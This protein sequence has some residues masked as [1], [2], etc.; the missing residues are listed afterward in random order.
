MKRYPTGPLSLEPYIFSMCYSYN[1]V[2]HP[3]DCDVTVIPGKPLLDP[4]RG[5]G[6]FR[7]SPAGFPE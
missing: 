3:V 5:A 4:D 1:R 2:K 7:I 6:I